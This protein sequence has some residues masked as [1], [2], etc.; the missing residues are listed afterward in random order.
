MW[1]AIF[2][3]PMAANRPIIGQSK[4]FLIILNLKCKFLGHFYA[5]SCYR[6]KLAK[7][8]SARW[9]T[10][11]SQNI[12]LN[13]LTLIYNFKLRFQFLEYLVKW[14]RQLDKS[15][16]FGSRPNRPLG[17]KIFYLDILFCPKNTIFL[18]QM[19]ERRQRYQTVY[20]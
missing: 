9:P 15:L 10:A 8:A 18:A 19:D 14:L 5:I 13:I 7:S 1:R 4:F 11:I 3:K 17:E 16:F 20:C 6:S 2:V 12:L